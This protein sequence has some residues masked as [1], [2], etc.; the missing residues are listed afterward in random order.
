MRVAIIG[1]AGRKEDGPK[2]GLGVFNRMVAKASEV[3][4]QINDDIILVSGGAAWADHVAVK[5]FL[6]NKNFSL[7]LHMP[8]KFNNGF[9]SNEKYKS[10][11][12]DPAQVATYYHNMFSKK[13]DFD[14]IN[15][16]IEAV[17]KGAEIYE[18][19][20]FFIRNVKVAN[21]DMIIA[22]TWGNGYEPKDGGT[23]NTWDRS[24]ARVKLH[25]PLSKL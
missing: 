11:Y 2:M 9:I 4:D 12:R 10:K 7:E 19:D 17:N 3:I 21:S 6:Q 22:F 24:S 8:S 25:F 18:Y 16:I 14:S 23:K 15:E 13:V 5:L 1:T 20:G